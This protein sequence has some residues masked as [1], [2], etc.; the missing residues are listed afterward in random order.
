M[1]R[2]LARVRIYTRMAVIG[3]SIGKRQ[4]VTRVKG[5]FKRTE[6][7]RANK[8]A[9]YVNDRD[10]LLS[11][12]LG[13]GPSKL[14]FREAVVRHLERYR[15]L[16]SKRREAGGQLFAR[17]NNY[18]TEIVKLTGPHRFDRRSRFSFTPDRPAE[19]TEI[20]RMFKRGLHYIGDWHTH[21][22][23]IPNP[24]GTDTR[25]I[26]ATFQNSRHELLHFVMVIVGTAA[27]P[28]A[29]YVG[30]CDGNNMEKLD[31]V[32]PE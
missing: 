4:W 27:L 32:S 17:F 19:Q 2:G 30:V 1:T 28:E 6:S 25:S 18:E 16:D 13:N 23:P 31:I 11:F 5:I 10:A 21:A 15:Q 29:L 24:S 26:Q 14:V 7:G 3:R 8:A 9:G 22:E 20:D 12:G